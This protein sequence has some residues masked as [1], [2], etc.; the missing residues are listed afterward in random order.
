MCVLAGGYGR[1]TPLIVILHH[2]S[3]DEILQI[4]VML[5]GNPW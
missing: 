2:G 1:L 5:S 3:Y 4:V